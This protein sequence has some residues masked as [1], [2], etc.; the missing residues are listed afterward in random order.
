MKSKNTLI[1]LLK[2]SRS[3]IFPIIILSLTTMLS[4]VT[5]IV[6]ALISREVINI[7]TGTTYSGDIKADIAKWALILLAVLLGQLTLVILD[8]HL[9]A[10]ISGKLEKNLRHHIFQTVTAKQYKDISKLH[11]GEIINRFMSDVD[12]VVSGIVNFVPNALSI[13]TKIIGGLVVIATISKNFVIIIIAVGIG[14]LLGATLIST[15]YKR[16]HKRVRRETGE[17]QSMTQEC[18]ENIVVIKSFSNR[19]ALLRR[20]DGLMNR[21]YK[22]KILRNHVTNIS[23]AGLFVVFTIGYYATLCWGALS[24]AS[25]N[26]IMDYGTLMAFLQIVSQIRTPLF[27]ASSLITS[28]YS[29]T[30]SA[31]RIIELENLPDEITS[32][33]E[34]PVSLYKT[35]NSIKVDGLSFGYTTDKKIIHDSSFEIPKGLTVAVTGPSGTGKSTLFRLLLGLFE[36]TTGNINFSTQNG[37]ININAS[38]RPLFAY[39]PQGNLVLS[40]TIADNVKFGN[41]DIDDETVLSALKDACLG[42][43]IAT[44]PDGINTVIG[45]R[46]LGLSEGQ[47]QRISVARALCCGAPILL[48]D[49]CT[50]ALDAET[51][52]SLLE[53][54]TSHRNKTV[55][56]ISHREAA[57]SICDQQLSLNNGVYT[58]K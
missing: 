54:I 12:I 28:F 37:D 55:L 42:D 36:P 43:L 18:V 24:I 19:T 47:I 20:L 52:I 16:L 15:F 26:G 5:F 21:L 56:F 51:E 39:V 29:A 27:N 34:D 7:A 40:G 23:N 48:L 41:P 50:S 30:A 38:T 8:S 45:E 10:S 11:S 13:F 4:S 53:N 35:I 49:E 25:G 14:L 31:E 58:L 1:W 22:S 46:G 44:L 6:L 57:L 33:I 32:S 9:K 17:V 2:M 3:Q